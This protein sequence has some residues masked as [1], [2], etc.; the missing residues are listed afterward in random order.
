MTQPQVAGAAKRAKEAVTRCAI[1]MCG[2]EGMK[3]KLKWFADHF[4]FF[5]HSFLDLIND[6]MTQMTGFSGVP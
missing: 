5:A 1:V 3:E 2:C 4:K 6:Q